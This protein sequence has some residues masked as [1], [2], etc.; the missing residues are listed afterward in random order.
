MPFLEL[1]NGKKKTILADFSV[2]KQSC[3]PIFSRF[4]VFLES[5]FGVATLESP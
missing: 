4:I 5:I 3:N 1:Q 2:Q